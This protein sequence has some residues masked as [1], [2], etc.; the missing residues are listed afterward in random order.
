MVRQVKL[1]ILAELVS[2]S[3]KYDCVPA[4][5]IQHLKPDTYQFFKDLQK[6]GF[7]PLVVSGIEYS[8]DPDVLE[9][10]EKD[11]CRI[12]NPKNAELF[13]PGY[14]DRFVG[15]ELKRWREA[16]KEYV[17]LEDGGYIGTVFH[18]ERPEYLKTCKGAVEQTRNGYWRYKELEDSG[19]LSIPVFTVA[20][21][22]LKSLVEAPE[23]GLAIARGLEQNLDRL[24]DSLNHKTVLVLGF[25]SIGRAIAR[26]LEGRNVSELLVF[27][28]DSVR[29]IEARLSNFKTAQKDDALRAADI[30]IGCTGRR[31]LLPEDYDL[32]KDGVIL[33]NGTSKRVEF[34]IE[35]LDGN[36]KGA[37][38]DGTAVTFDTL[39]KKIT[40]LAKGEPINFEANVSVSPETIDIVM[41]EMFVCMQR[42]MSGALE[43]KTYDISA[44][45]E[46]KISDL[47][48]EF[49]QE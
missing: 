1:P 4:I 17:V 26:A 42:I 15:S 6:A 36:S 14:W 11:G 44:E 16:G 24:H 41:S 43:N 38:A 47:W 31:S 29:L 7:E 19:R 23:V 3:A 9:Q 30:I 35:W 32:V 45:D 25:G 40:V 33:V 21:S 39:S 10:L 12:K 18:Q 27:D 37:V 2:R 34:D 8:T 22:K 20:N 28:S 46:R 49:Y 48:M 5:S 13:D